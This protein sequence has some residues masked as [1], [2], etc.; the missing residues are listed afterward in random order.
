[1]A[2]A[3]GSALNATLDYIASAA[4]EFALQRIMDALPAN[5]RMQISNVAAT[6]EIS[7][8]LLIA[9]W[10]A[11]DPVMR[12]HDPEWME[13]AGAHSI[14]SMGAQL[15]GGII[16]KGSPLEF[17]T[18]PIKL[19]RLY[20]HSGNME[21]VE[22]DDGRAILRLVG[23]DQPNALFC[24]RQTGGLRRALELAG[25]NRASARHVRCVAE[26]DAFCEWEL[27]WTV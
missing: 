8:D 23:F 10:E 19:F 13:K 17:L 2:V 6:D 3:K 26:G 9:V 20:Y 11:A 4:G 25:G 5:V 16:R 7:F 24:R 21:M 12:A 22:Q 1:M 18:Q 27:K 14:E 15:Y